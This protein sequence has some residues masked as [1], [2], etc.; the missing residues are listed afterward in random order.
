[1]GLAGTEILFTVP[2]SVVSIYFNLTETP[3][4]AWESW[5]NSH[6][7]FSLIYQI[8]S[9]EWRVTTEIV[10]GLELTRWAYVIC[11][12]VFFGFFGFADEARRNYRLAYA[13]VAKRVGLSTGAMS[14]TGTWT[15]NGYVT[16]RLTS[17]FPALIFRISLPTAPTPMR[18]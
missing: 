4:Q 3:L 15:A 5:S 9:V 10:A 16:L 6:A 18:P 1:M 11:A 8:P 2:L 17:N 14:A 7:D 13:S 12:F